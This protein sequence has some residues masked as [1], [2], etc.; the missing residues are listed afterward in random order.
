[1]REDGFAILRN[2]FDARESMIATTLAELCEFFLE[3]TPWV[4]L[5]ASRSQNKKAPLPP[6]PVQCGQEMSSGCD[7]CYFTLHRPLLKRFIAG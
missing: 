1:L 7:H 3:R 6:F 5:P 4:G 2:V